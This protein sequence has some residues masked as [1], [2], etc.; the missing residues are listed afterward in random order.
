[1]WQTSIIKTALISKTIKPIQATQVCSHIKIALQD[2]LRVWYWEEEPPENLALEASRAS[3]QKFHRA[4]VNRDSTLGECTQGLMCTGT[5][6]K[7][8]PP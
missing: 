3:V 4:G 5:Q 6:H 8:V 1:M 2:S 7:A